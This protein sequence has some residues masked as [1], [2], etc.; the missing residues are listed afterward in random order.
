M[1]NHKE[2]NDKGFIQVFKIANKDIALIPRRSTYEEHLSKSK[3]F[4]GDTYWIARTKL[5][6]DKE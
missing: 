4:F 3:D 2:H 6:K 5:V 1:A